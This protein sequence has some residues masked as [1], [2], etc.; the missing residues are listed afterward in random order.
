MFLD[1]EMEF[2]FEEKGSFHSTKQV[3]C[4][5]PAV[6]A[7]GVALASAYMSSKGGDEGGG[8]DPEI[9][10][11]TVSGQVYQDMDMVYDLDASMALE[12]LTGKMNEWSGQ[13]REFFENTFQPFQ[14]SLIEANQ[15][16]VP[17]IVENS[18][19][20]LKSN[21]K[22]LMGGD[23]LKESFRG[24]MER[25]GGDISKFAENF[26][27]QVDAIP[28]AEQRMGEAVAGVEAR[29]GEAGKELKRQMNAQGLGVTQASKREL[30][31]E[32]AKAKASAV[33]V[34]KQSAREE[35]LAATKAGID[36]AA[37]VQT[38]QANLL[39][40]Q[41]NLTQT[42]AMLTPQVGGVQETGGVGEA[43]KI[44]ADLT[45]ASAEKV[46]GSRTATKDAQFTQPGIQ[47]P[48]FF[49]KETGQMTDAAGNVMSAPAG[50]GGGSDADYWRRRRNQ[51]SGANSFGG[52]PGVG[53]ADS[54]GGVGAVGADTGGMGGG[55]LGASG[56]GDS[57]GIGGMDSAGGGTGIGG[58]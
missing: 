41:Q 23:F 17:G 9:L 26:S 31:I 22:D 5:W 43:G 40:S 38:S 25:S 15:D 4:I 20:A 29:F 3:N 11:K 57:S 46:L 35:N 28:S 48:R 33:G 42:G 44:G 34:A 16:L 1:D 27:K 30:A 51:L 56:V 36:V 2:G 14:A 49:D 24:Q 37:G 8:K 7:G 58:F 19:A 53:G 32:K 50:G 18:G 12:D 13:D 54:S 47:T 21:L 10:P 55:G 52:G 45:Q 39:A 6:I